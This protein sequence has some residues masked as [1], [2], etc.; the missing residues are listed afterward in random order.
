VQ[1]FL[2]V[3]DTTTVPALEANTSSTAIRSQRLDDLLNTVS[4]GRGPLSRAAKAALKA[5]MP[6]ELR[7]L[8]IGVTQ[9]NLV[10]G[11]PPPPEA[12]VIEGLRRR[13]AGE[14]V[15]LSE[16]LDRDLVALWGYGPYV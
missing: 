16:Y 4:I 15:A 13:F 1:R 10:M 5:V 11:P 8:A 7:R 9:R 12:D 6:A 14:V 3:D 2:G